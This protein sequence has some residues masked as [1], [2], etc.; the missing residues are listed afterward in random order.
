MNI[1]NDSFRNPTVWLDSTTA[2]KIAIYNEDQWVAYDNDE[3]IQMKMDFA[4]ER[5]EAISNSTDV[6][7]AEGDSKVYVLP[8]IWDSDSPKVSCQPPYTFILPPFP[9]NKTQT[10]TWPSVTTPVII[11]ADGTTSTSKTIISV[12]DFV[13]TGLPF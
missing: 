7:S 4:N 1:V 6:F 9:L 2:V 3:T 12:P 5:S 10:V 8:K 11:S 13:V